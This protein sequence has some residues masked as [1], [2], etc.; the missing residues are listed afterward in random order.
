MF[1]GVF[2]EDL[3]RAEAE[4]VPP[5]WTDEKEERR[6]HHRGKISRFCV[7]L[8]CV[9]QTRFLGLISHRIYTLEQYNK[10]GEI[11]FLLLSC[12]I[13]RIIPGTILNRER[14]T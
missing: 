8:F 3:T 10:L 13:E 1:L 5:T 7:F 9:A 14:E 12:I 6:L 11:F 2:N 4:E